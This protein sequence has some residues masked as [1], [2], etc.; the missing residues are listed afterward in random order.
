[1]ERTG[2]RTDA[3]S[4]PILERASSPRKT[5]QSRVASGAACLMAHP[6]AP[7]KRSSKSAVVAATATPRVGPAARSARHRDTRVVTSS[8]AAHSSVTEPGKALFTAADPRRQVRI[9]ELPRELDAI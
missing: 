6:A 1:M 8:N 2:F 3:A 7:L 4:A 5:L 9:Q